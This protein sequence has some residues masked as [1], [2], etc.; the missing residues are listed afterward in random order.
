MCP[1]QRLRAGYQQTQARTVRDLWP[2]PGLASGERLQGGLHLVARVSIS[3][4]LRGDNPIAERLFRLGNFPQ[5]GEQLTI[6]KISRDVCGMRFDQRAE[7]PI[8]G[9]IIAQFGALD[10]KA[11]EGKWIVWVSLDE[12]L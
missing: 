1:T 12:T 8:G 3:G 11:I 10:C 5:T 2:R 7:M 9:L 4:F 6:L